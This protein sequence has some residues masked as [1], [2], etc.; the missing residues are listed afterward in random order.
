MGA[1]MLTPWAA[2]A[3]PLLLAVL[4][5]LAGRRL[6]SVTRY[7]ALGGP[8]T[9]LATGVSALLA[10][11]PTPAASGAQS[12]EVLAG[13]P[14]AVGAL[15][16]GTLAIDTLGA[17]MLVGVG[18]VAT[19]V[20]LYSVGYMAQEPDVPRYTATILLFCSAMG[21]LLTATTFVAL[22]VGWELMGACSY[23]LIG[24]WRERPSASAAAMKAF[25]TTRVGD[26]GILL[27][28]A[29]LWK[30]TGSVSIPQV[31]ARVPELG[32]GVVTAAALLILL[33]AVGKSAQFP[34]H[35]WLPDAMEGPTPVSALIHAATMVAAGVFLIVRVWPLVAASETALTVMLVV[36]ALTAFGAARAATVQHDIKK[37]LA[38]STI[39]QLGFMF[40]AL[41]AGAWEV[42][43]FHLVTHAAFKGL[44]FLAAGSLIHGTGTQDLREM[45][46]A[47]KAMPV[48]GVPWILGALAL[49]GVPPLAGFF[50]KDEVLATVF[51]HAPVAGVALVG[52]SVLT[53]YYVTR[54]TTLALFGERRG[55]KAHESPATM[56]VP[57]VVLATGAAMLG[58]AGHALAETLGAEPHALDPGVVA[59]SLG[60]LGVGVSAATFALGRAARE[61]AR[62]EWRLNAWVRSGFGIDA[63]YQR[64]IVD[65]TVAAAAWVGERFD[66]RVIDGAVEKT[67]PASRWIGARINAFQSGETEV[68]ASL[69]G[70]GFVLLMGLVLWL[71]RG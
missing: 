9:V 66:R 29:I 30:A 43:I 24:F 53:A 17:V 56:T 65:P 32:T 1:D 16:T 59:A 68:Y 44:L 54:A 37:V 51:G 14:D 20:L 22:L 50:S 28:V 26:M 5:T 42:A 33:G 3:V 15:V 62:S 67:V 61:P 25:V 6:A 31:L 13:W 46:G 38:Y 11:V 58:F 18:A 39:S 70:V 52:A 57:L 55:E 69:V 34:L 47:F 35:V 41:G 71:G 36:G 7:V 48:T 64:V 12:G 45:G 19:M 40:A 49:A 21:L 27:A 63:F 8:L 23:L 10:G 2:V 60:A 4:V